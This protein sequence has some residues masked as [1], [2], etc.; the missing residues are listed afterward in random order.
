L[1][2]PHAAH[3]DDDDVNVEDDD[4]DS[5]EGRC[6]AAFCGTHVSN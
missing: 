6:L 2:L 4:D 5:E 1:R 3:D